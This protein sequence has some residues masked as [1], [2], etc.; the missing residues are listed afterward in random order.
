MPFNFQGLTH[1]IAYIYIYMG[2]DSA[3]A[4]SPGV[5]LTEAQARGSI[6]TLIF[7]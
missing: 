7:R 2:L 6:F 3:S 4:V 1:I 5:G